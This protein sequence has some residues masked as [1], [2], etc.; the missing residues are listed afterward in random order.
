LHPLCPKAKGCFKRA[1]L[2]EK[3]QNWSKFYSFAKYC[4]WE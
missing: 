2:K 4:D 1:S 3:C